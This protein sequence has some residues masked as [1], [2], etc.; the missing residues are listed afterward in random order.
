MRIIPPMKAVICFEAA[1]RLKSFKLAAVELNVT[2]GA[3]SHQ[4]AALEN[5][6][7]KELFDR[8]HR[9][10]E[11]THSGRKLFRQSRDYSTKYGRSHHRPWGAG[12]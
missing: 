4:I 3:I 8:S 9:Q 11:L 2:P 1:A 5:F 7:G 10:L 12:T 6:V